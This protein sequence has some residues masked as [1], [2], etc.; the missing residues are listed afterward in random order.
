M[1]S[2]VYVYK[3]KERQQLRLTRFKVKKIHGIYNYDIKLNED[4]TFLYGINGCG[5]TTILNLIT[6]VITGRLFDLFQYSFDELTLQ[7][8]EIEEENSIVVRNENDSEFVITFRNKEHKFTK[9]LE[10]LKT[11]NQNE[12]EKAYL[13]QYPWLKEIKDLFNFVYLPLS[14]NNKP[15]DIE[16]ERKAWRLSIFE[17]YG[18]EKIFENPMNASL[19]SVKIIVKDTVL[20]I[21]SRI[22]TIDEKFRNDMFKSSFHFIDDS[23]KEIPKIKPLINNKP[24]LKQ[25]FKDL[26]ILDITFE[27]QIDEYYLQLEKAFYAIEQVMIQ[28]NPK[29]NKNISK[30]KPESKLIFRN[31]MN[32]LMTFVSNQSRI[33]QLSEL[34]ELADAINLEKEQVM[35][36]ITKFLNLINS[37]F[38]ESN[39]NF[40]ID[41]DS[42]EIYFKATHNSNPINI[43]KLSSGEKQLLILFSYVILEL[44]EDHEGIFI[45]DEPELS[46]HLDWQRRYVKSL[47]ETNNNIQ[48]LFATHSPEIIGQYRDKAFEVKPIIDNLQSGEVLLK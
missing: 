17:D 27:K 16:I 24:K 25:T 8:R 20:N 29:Q 12:V 11:G 3:K 30:K 46:L 14:R 22:N 45:V 10:Q 6:I 7:Y 9:E 5:K 13:K 41:Y 43:E 37:Y 42:G 48:L 39:K 1:L 26:G 32:S 4:V 15:T 2:N 38:A 33:Q 36:P 23:N 31:N 18:R 28:Q 19:T 34:S 40:V 47:L 21:M 44:K 35:L